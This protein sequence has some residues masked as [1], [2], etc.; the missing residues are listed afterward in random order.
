ME[1]RTISRASVVAYWTG[2][3]R[4]RVGIDRAPYGIL[5]CV[6]LSDGWDIVR[7]TSIEPSAEMLDPKR[8]SVFTEVG[9][10]RDL[11]QL[12]AD[13]ILSFSGHCLV[14][15]APDGDWYMGNLDTTDGSI[16]CWGSYGHDL[17]RAIRSL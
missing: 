10:R 7:A 12:E 14:K 6:G 11:E 9:S 3:H 15:V 1:L 13:C 2:I 5:V 16:V 17:E 8:H 4:D